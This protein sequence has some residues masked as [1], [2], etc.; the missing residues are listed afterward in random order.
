MFVFAGKG[1]MTPC[2]EFNF[3]MD[4]ESAYIVLEEYVCPTHV[5]TWEFAC[6]NKLSW[7][8]IKKLCGKNHI[9]TLSFIISLPKCFLKEKK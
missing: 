1:N 6:R 3:L 2:A 8:R 7:V 4:P 5:A 9:S